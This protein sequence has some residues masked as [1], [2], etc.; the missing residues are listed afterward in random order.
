MK[1]DKKIQDLKILEKMTW[2]NLSSRLHF[3]IWLHDLSSRL[4]FETSLQN[5]TP[6]LVFK[7]MIWLHDLSSRL[8]FK[9]WLHDLFSRQRFD[10]MNWLHNLTP[11][12]ALTVIWHKIDR[13]KSPTVSASNH[14]QNLKHSESEKQKPNTI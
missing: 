4:V 7:T 6:W 3:K 1:T 8:D 14:A 5:L 12:F 9:I 13:F 10:S 11:W 2:T